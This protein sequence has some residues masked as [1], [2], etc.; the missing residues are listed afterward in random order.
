M[1]LGISQN[2]YN[3]AQER[4]LLHIGTCALWKTNGNVRDICR[5]VHTVVLEAL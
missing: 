4:S 1:W 3:N 2:H 5:G